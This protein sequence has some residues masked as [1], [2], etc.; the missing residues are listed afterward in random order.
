MFKQALLDSVINEYADVP[1]ESE[2]SYSFADKFDYSERRRPLKA[3]RYLRTVALIAVLIS[4]FLC[5]S[6]FANY[7]APVQVALV[8]HNSGERYSFTAETQDIGELPKQLSPQCPE[9]IPDGYKLSLSD[10]TSND[11]FQYY[12]NGDNYITYTQHTLSS[13]PDAEYGFAIYGATVSISQIVINETDVYCLVDEDCG[14]INIVWASDK[15]IFYLKFYGDIDNNE[16]EHVFK[17]IRPCD[18]VPI[19]SSD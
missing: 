1:P 7:N 11:V 2:L 5:G 4:A 10:F 15:Y 19:V 14:D 13:D 6:M 16:I 9:Y 18:D 8:L 17:S 12:A 3:R